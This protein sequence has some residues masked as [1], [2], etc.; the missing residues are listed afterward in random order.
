MLDKDKV[1][2]L[3]SPYSSDDALTRQLRYLMVVN[4]ATQLV[5]DHGLTLIEPI[6]MSH[7]HAQMFGLPS[8]YDFWKRRDR[9]LIDRS[10][11]VVVALINGWKESVG[12][13]DEIAYAQAQGKPV[14]YL[15]PETMSMALY[16][17][18]KETV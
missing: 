1:Y 15:D 17:I 10:D 11:G 6:A 5:R 8:G 7:H 4:V 9:M 18:T 13:K 3:A 16:L 12:V 14:F 2:Y